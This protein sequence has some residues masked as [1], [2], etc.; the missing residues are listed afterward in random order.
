MGLTPNR[1]NKITVENIINL[2]T[3]EFSISARDLTGK[4]RTQAVSLPRQIG[5]YLARDHTDH[6]LEAVGKYF[7][8]RDHTTVLYAVTKIK[9]RSK[10]DRM[11]NELLANLS[12][13]LQSGNFE[14]FS[15][16]V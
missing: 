6:S 5:M 1:P 12:A 2:I 3:S 11:F 7:G 8:G 15:S 4:G 13:R 14:G 16:K 9:N 10:A